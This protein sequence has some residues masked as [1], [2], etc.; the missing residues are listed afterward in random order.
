MTIVKAQNVT[1]TLERA[2]LPSVQ[3]ILRVRRMPDTDDA[4]APE[5]APAGQAF[6]RER[7]ALLARITDLERELADQKSDA[8]QRSSAAFEQGAEAARSECVRSEAERIAALRDGIANARQMFS[9]RLKSLDSLAIDIARVALEKILGD[10]S[11]YADLV[12]S[13]IRNRVGMLASGAALEI[14]VAQADFAD[15]AALDRLQAAIPA[16]PPIK[17]VADPAL[18]EGACIVGLSLGRIDAGIPL[19]HERIIATLSEVFAND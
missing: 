3:N 6:E 1:L 11:R 5:A 13:T 4:R 17:L 12:T 15:A 7:E 10:T 2:T 14:R 9:D 19:Q 16:M 8:E 18:A